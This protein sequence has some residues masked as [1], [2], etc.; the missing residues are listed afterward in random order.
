MASA[1]EID[2]TINGKAAHIANKDSGIDSIKIAFEL[3]NSLDGFEDVIFNCG[4]ISSIGARNIICDKVILEC[5]LRSFYKIRRKSFLNK[6]N[7]IAKELSHKSGGNIFV[8][9]KSYIPEV[10]NNLC[11]FEKFR[12]LIDEV[13]SPVYQAEDFSFYGKDC[14]SLFLFLGVGDTLPLHSN[15]FI[16]DPSVLEKGLKTLYTIATTY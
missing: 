10:R 5:S 3:L 9:S 15:K 1:T 2:I 12:H 6:L 14:K 13:V 4:K 11:L 16:F 7:F 8:N